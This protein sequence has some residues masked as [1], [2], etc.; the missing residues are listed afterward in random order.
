MNCQ[1]VAKLR[2]P[3]DA[4]CQ[5][6]DIG[7][8]PIT[9][10]KP[11]CSPQPDELPFAFD[12]KTTTLWIF[13]CKTREWL[14]FTKFNVCQLD[15]LNLDNITNI[16]D[17]LNIA[18]N[19]SGSGECKQ[20]TIT[21]GE[22]AERI[23]ECLKLETKIITIGEG[24]GN[25]VKITIEGLPLDPVY[26]T[27]RNIWSEG[28]SGT[29]A[30]PL[31]IATH[32]PIC[33]WPTKS[34]AQV[35]AANVKHLGA[36][37]DGEMARVP[38]PLKVC[39]LPERTQEQVDASNNKKIVA[40]VNG[41]GVKIPFP[42]KPCEYKQLTEE[43][44]EA[45]SEKNLVACVDGE[46]VKVPYPPQAC[47]YRQLTE[48]Q[49]E[50]AS[51]KN[52]VA[53]VDGEA[54]KVPYPGTP[55]SYPQYTQEQVQAAS[56]VD[57]VACVDGR[58]VKIPIPP[59]FFAE[60]PCQ[61]PRATQTM[62]ENA[63][64]KD[65]IVC[66]D[67]KDYKVPVPSSF[68]DPGYL[69][70][71]EVIGKP[72]SAPLPGTGPIR[73]DCNG[74]IYVW[75]CET[76][77]WVSFD[78]GPVGTPYSQVEEQINDPCTEIRFKGWRNNL[79]DPCAEPVIFNSSQLANIVNV[80]IENNQNEDDITK[81]LNR[82]GVEI[83]TVSR[84]HHGFRPFHY[85]GLGNVAVIRSRN[86][87]FVR[88][89]VGT[90]MESTPPFG[91][92][93][94]RLTNNTNLLKLYLI[95]HGIRLQRSFSLR[96][97]ANVAA[98]SCVSYDP[99]FCNLTTRA[100][101]YLSQHGYSGEPLAETCEERRARVESDPIG[102]GIISGHHAIVG[103]DNFDISTHPFGWTANLSVA[104]LSKDD[105]P[106]RLEPWRG[107]AGHANGGWSQMSNSSHTTS[108]YVLPGQTV[109]ISQEVLFSLRDI[110]SAGE[111]QFGHG[112]YMMVLGFAASINN[113]SSGGGSSDN[114][115]AGDGDDND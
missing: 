77:T 46:A 53:C 75:V 94:L 33:K 68:F 38:F 31:K 48:E 113:S 58:N 87:S 88:G 42:P 51:D 90:N 36:C 67:G 22:L 84:A 6:T 43:Q 59:G 62:V 41:E 11:I 91:M 30:D 63:T 52:L 92:T 16:C 49:V 89:Q 32:D 21:L 82:L 100:S 70:V 78:T 15:A 50:A 95:F 14:D 81:Y 93:N 7:C 2:T 112:Q 85:T 45:A 19:Y 44:V 9:D 12:P 107:I 111:V 57:V 4:V 3:L 64:E 69:C 96:N 24:E 106:V 109:T 17:I 86:G 103:T 20:G 97:Q 34:Q 110:D 66:V 98:Y 61:F 55:C 102:Q 99:P 79:N 65:V 76:Q 39:E 47:E 28:G 29:E 35:D 101:D 71:P 26:V 23:L 37:L 18:V 25:K 115:G 114:D 60:T 74:T 72:T 40:C 8:V 13:S 5:T 27:G 1:D 73:V 10:G 80:C 105:I 104:T 54:V 108:I 83:Y 56:D